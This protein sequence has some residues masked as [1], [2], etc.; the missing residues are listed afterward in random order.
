MGDPIGTV[1][2]A[3]SAAGLATGV[4]TKITELAWSCGA[5]WVSEYY[6]NHRAAVVA[7]AKENCDLFLNSL[8]HK[9]GAL[10][11]ESEITKSLMTTA[12]GEP[13]FSVLLQ[14]AVLTSSQ[15]GDAQKHE[16]L[17]D[18]ICQRLK[19]SPDSMFTMASQMA[20]DAV[21]HCTLNQLF[22]LGFSAS[23]L[24]ISSQ[25]SDFAS[26]EEYLRNCSEWFSHRLA[27]YETLEIGPLDY[28]HL[29][30][31]ACASYVRLQAINTRDLDGMIRDL[32]SRGPYRLNDGFIDSLA[33]GEKIRHLWEAKK[34]R[35]LLLTSVGQMIGILVSDRLCGA[36]ATSFE[37]WQRS[38]TSTPLET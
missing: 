2:E 12:M 14:K 10:E 38:S 27:P 34:M 18:V 17:S 29:Q 37:E 7:K 13:S 24:H 1:I 21:A 3:A 35:S 6:A 19:S 4:G 20:V 5:K 25:R 8:A 30:A 31:V 36:D 16:I 33:L 11:Q 23:L 26:P 32:W 15:T 22:I 28:A 9:V